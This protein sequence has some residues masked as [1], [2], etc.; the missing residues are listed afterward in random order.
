MTSR[1]RLGLIGAAILA[2]QLLPAQQLQ[3]ITINFPTRSGASWPMYLAKEAGYYQKYG[4]D[5]TLQFGA[6]PAGIAMLV[7]GEAAMTNYSMEQAMQAATKDGSMVMLGSS[8]N[9]GAFALMAAKGINQ[10]AELKGKRFAVSQIGDAPYNYAIA[11]LSHFGLSSRDVQWVPI[12]TDA[13]GRAAALMSGRA[14]ATLL[15]APQY[16]KV[17]SAGYKLLANMADFNDVFAS[18]VYLFKK[19]TITANP[20][21]P[22][23]LIKAHA[24][25]IKRYYD[26]KP[27][28][29]KAYL[30]YDKADPADVER[31]YDIQAKGQMLERIP[32]VLTGA[33]KSILNQADSEAATRIRDYDFHTVID[34]SVVDRLVKEGYFEK[35]FGAG[36]KSEEE[37]KAKEAFR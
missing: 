9:K 5:V 13:S 25:A 17:E 4:Y 7:S 31:I 37:R 23:A 2:P 10:G 6:H 3:K 16:F 20:K 1:L 33:V 35:L 14:D 18:T 27:M 19:S 15:T 11:M 28:A 26:D 30:A 8:L 21:L 32:Y 12:G 36:I 22:E 34:N 24:E 29:V